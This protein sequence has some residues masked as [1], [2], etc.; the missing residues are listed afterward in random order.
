MPPPKKKFTQ[1]PPRELLR[2]D[3]QGVQIYKNL[4]RRRRF[5]LFSVA[6]VVDVSGHFQL[7]SLIFD[8]FGRFRT[9]PD[10]FGHF[11]TFSDISVVFI[12]IVPKEGGPRS[13]SRLAAATRHE[14]SN[15][16]ACF[17]RLE[18]HYAQNGARL[19]P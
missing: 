9:F 6:F 2:P 19:K 4:A 5:G 16:L 18:C 15:R 11:R 12:C 3:S 13:A 1:P 10:G 14:D 7:F 8:V 17:L